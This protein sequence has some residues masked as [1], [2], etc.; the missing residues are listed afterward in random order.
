MTPK[1]QRGMD[2]CC[3]EPRHMRE[4]AMRA[5]VL[6]GVAAFASILRL[7]AIY[8]RDTARPQSSAAA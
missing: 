4:S 1:R 6:V 7:T 3:I 2:A 8:D 5:K